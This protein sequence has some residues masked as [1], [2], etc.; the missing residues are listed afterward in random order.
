MPLQ[1]PATGVV[2]AAHARIDNRAELA[3]ALRS[4]LADHRVA[5]APHALSDSKLIL[6][7]YLRWG[8]DCVQHLTG[9]WAMALWDPRTHTLLLARDPCGVSSFYTYRDSRFFA[10][11]SSIKGLLA[12]EQAPKHPNLLAI[13]RLL[14]VWYGERDAEQSACETAYDG[15]QRLPA[16]HILTITADK[17]TTRRYWDFRNISPLRL[18]SDAA[19]LEAFLEI[20]SEA[21]RCRLPAPDAPAGV[22]AT[23]S[24]GLDSGS[25]CALAARE[26]GACGQR[27]PVFTSVPIHD[28]R[29]TTPHGWYGDESAL[30]ER[31]QQFIGNLDLHYIRAGDIGPLAAIERELALHD[32]PMHAAGNVYWLHALLATLQQQGLG[33]LLTGQGGNA[34]ISWAGAPVDLRGL[35]LAGQWRTAWRIARQRLIGPIVAQT[36]KIFAPPSHLGREAWAAYSAINPEWA[37]SLD[38]AQRMQASGHDPTFAPPSDPDQERRFLVRAIGATGAIWAEKGAAYAVEVRDPTTDKRVVEFCLAIPDAHYRSDGQERA[39]IRRAMQGL[40]PDEVRLNTQRGLQAA[41]LGQRLL[42]ELP[43]V[44]T[45]LARLAGSS[46][47]RQVLDLPKINRVLHDLQREVNVTTTRQSM[48]ILTRGLMVGLFLLRFDNH[49]G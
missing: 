13:A 34:T 9:D 12:L 2:L 44:Q 33:I 40:L 35:L 26:L 19:C 25:I 6:H 31:T 14:T 1:H 37:R 11:A 24:S 36:R 49:V 30:V 3:A 20:Y 4:H 15:I 10:F 46:L 29:R 28:T 39:L 42:A 21:V 45:L 41:D 27:L 47:A 17:T 22:G 5:P 18:K 48:T 16:A 7:A 38:L 8:E 32:Q 23:L 43:Q